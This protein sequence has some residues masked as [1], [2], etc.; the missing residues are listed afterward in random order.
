[1]IPTPFGF[2]STTYNPGM[3]LLSTKTGTSA[4]SIIFGAS[5]FD[6][7]VYDEYEFHILNLFSSASGNLIDC[8]VSEDGGMTFKTAANYNSEYS[9]QDIGGNSLTGTS[10]SANYLR[11]SS[12]VVG[13][14]PVNTH[15]YHCTLRLMAP[16]D[17][18]HPKQFRFDATY[19]NNI[20]SQLGSIRGSGWW[21]GDT[22]PING[23]RFEIA[24]G[25]LN[26]TAT[27][28]AYGYSIK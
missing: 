5:D 3:V 18:G 12:G 10:G 26:I 11:L 22:N 19:V 20:V 25:T 16:T 23:I 28:R 6:W 15:P 1:M 21:N 27:I 2:S 4:T 8:V 9:G 13:G 14:S 7:T 24:A 17:T